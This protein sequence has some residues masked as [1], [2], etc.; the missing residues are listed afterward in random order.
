MNTART[1]ITQA[2]ENIMPHEVAQNVTRIT[3]AIG[4][5][6][7]PV[8]TK[9]AEG[10]TLNAAEASALNQLVQENSRNNLYQR[11][12]KED[13]EGTGKG[14]EAR[15]AEAIAYQNAYEFGGRKAGR[16][17]AVAHDPVR[18]EAM[19]IMIRA[20]KD[21]MAAK[22][23]QIKGKAEAIKKQAE[24]LLAS[25][26]PV[27]LATWAKAREYVAQ[28]QAIGADELGDLEIL[29]DAP[30]STEGDAPTEAPAE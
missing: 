21:Q 30:V 12:K 15:L 18:A 23:M 4:K 11:W 7:V 24:V 2:K 22:N 26:K 25:E 1:A 27:A 17:T 14:A 5:I 19:N 20:I 8:V 13:T 10:H 29:A 28:L 9:F 16:T 6:E 3:Y